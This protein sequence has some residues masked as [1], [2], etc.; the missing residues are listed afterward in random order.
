MY[1]TVHVYLHTR[2]AIFAWYIIIIPLVEAISYE[3]NWSLPC[4]GKIQYHAWKNRLPHIE[5]ATCGQYHTWHVKPLPCVVM[6]DLKVKL[7]LP[8]FTVHCILKLVLRIVT[9]TLYFTGHTSVY[10]P[11]ADLD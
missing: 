5:A 2:A 8:Y 11:G 6:G 1:S 9:N 3:W 4:R 10:H 7:I